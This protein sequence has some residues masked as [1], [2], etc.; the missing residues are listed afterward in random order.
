MDSSDSNSSSCTDSEGSTAES[1]I[2]I[3]F[4][5][6]ASTA[7]LDISEPYYNKRP[8]HTSALSGLQWVDELI[9]GHP[10]RIK[11]AFGMQLHIFET[12]LRTLRKMEYKDSKHVE[13]REQLGIFL[14]TCVT[15][16]TIRHVAERFQR[17][18]ATIS[19]CEP[20]N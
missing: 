5:N 7:V 14:Y 2:I 4:V 11:I 8:H 6:T 20:S 18:N 19:K 1:D 9:E 13:L 16:L 12:L 15:G 10:D 3:T 17:S